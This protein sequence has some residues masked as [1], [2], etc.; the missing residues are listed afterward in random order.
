MFKIELGAVNQTERSKTLA[1][2]I[3]RKSRDEEQPN[4]NRV[5]IM[6]YIITNLEN[7]L[8]TF[9]EDLDF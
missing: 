5:N 6:W 8:T 3:T 9:Q 7:H 4:S 2:L 1:G